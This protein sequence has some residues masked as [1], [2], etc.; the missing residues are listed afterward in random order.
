[1]IEE[2]SVLPVVHIVAALAVF[3]E[4]ALMRIGVARHTIPGK[5]E[6]RFREI[7]PLD[8]RFYVGNHS[9]RSVAFFTGHAA[10]LSLERIA[11]QTVIK[12]LCGRLP[13]DERKAFAVVFPVAPHAVLPV[14]VLHLEPRVIAMV[15]CERSCNLFVA[16]QA[17]EGWCAGSE[18][19]TARTLGRPR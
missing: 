6:K 19:M 13:M 7:L 1:M 2:F 9:C 3:A 16:V 14:W 15:F 5:P 11:R 8:Q 18:L 10:V 17:F 4:L 12:L